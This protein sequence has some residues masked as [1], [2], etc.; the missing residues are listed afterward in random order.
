LN[1]TG[2]VIQMTIIYELSKTSA[3][4]TEIP[5]IYKDRRAGKTKVGIN[6]QF[7][8]DVFEYAKHATKI[9]IE[10]SQRFF[11][12][13]VVGFT[14]FII[15]AVG[16]EVFYRLGLSAGLAAAC[17]AELSIISN[18]TFNNL[19]TFAK[20]KISGLGKTLWKFLQFNF[21]SAGAII[22]QALVVGGLSRLFGPEYR[23]IYL[24]IAVGFFVIPYNYF[25][26]THVIWRVAGKKKPKKT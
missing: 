2:F 24:V 3:K 17:G 14:G 13:A 7:I 12:F 26:Y 22:I 10:R 25:M 21:T 23:Q 8:K 1:V 19:W 6:T 4:F 16:L 9:R 5:A 15:N 18:F 11:K 20:E